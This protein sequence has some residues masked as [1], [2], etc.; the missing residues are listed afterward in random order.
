MSDALTPQYLA[1]DIQIVHDIF[2]D[3]FSGLTEADWQRPTEANGWTLQETVAHLDA[4]ALGYQQTIEA[5]LANKPFDFGGVTRREELP[6]WNEKQ[7]ALRQQWPAADICGSFLATLHRAAASAGQRQTAELSQ[8]CPLPFYSRPI[9]LA[10]L[11]GGQ[12]AHPG[13][14]HAAQV[15]NGAG[16]PPLWH[17]Y[18]PDLQQRQLSRL[19]HLMALS[20]W[21]ERGGALRAIVNFVI[22]KRASWQLHLSPEGCEVRQGKGI[23]PSLIIWFRSMD[24]LC[25]ALTLQ[26]S[27]IRAALT[28]QAFA[29]G[30]LPL[31]FRLEYLFNPTSGF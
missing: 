4:V 9:T 14:V 2:R 26:I 23:R 8:S 29:W 18:P 31:L 15:A 30:N 27:P 28:G 21:P 1:A 10:D 6:I 16:I 24:T 5:I 11:Y 17:H 22:P 20:Y 19:L 13:L 12:A 7:I 25:R 3:F